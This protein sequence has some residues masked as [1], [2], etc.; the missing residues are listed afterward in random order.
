MRFLYEIVFL[1]N[2]VQALSVDCPDMIN[3][4]KGLGVD[5]TQPAI[6][7][8]INI[9]CCSVSG[10]TCFGQRVTSINW[11]SKGLNGT[12]NGTAVPVGVTYLDISLNLLSG[13][14][15]VNY[16]NAIATLYNDVNRLT[17]TIPTTLP[18][19]L[20]DFWVDG[21]FLTGDV[22]AFPPSLVKLALGYP[23]YPGND[24]TGVLRLNRPIRIWINNNWITD[25][26]IQDTSQISFPQCDFSE[27]PLLGNANIAGLA[28]TKN[29]LYSPSMLPNTRSS[30]TLK[31][32]WVSSSTITTTHGQITTSLSPNEVSTAFT[33]TSTIPKTSTM[34]PTMTSTMTFSPGVI[35]VGL[36]TSILEST[37]F[38]TTTIESNVEIATVT[39]IVQQ[40]L[41]A[42][43]AI[44]STITSFSNSYVYHFNSTTFKIV[45]STNVQTFHQFAAIVHTITIAELIR[46]AIKL[47]NDVA[48]LAIVI[49][50]MPI[51][52]GQRQIFQSKRK[53]DTSYL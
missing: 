10:I 28:C 24:F 16:P 29:G 17:G 35:T 12:I 48:L 14:I 13:S 22:P 44:A 18:T 41:L 40:T 19:S 9:N 8:A 34:V 47:L 23:G 1:L 11:Q 27:N 53:T 2:R 39:N 6:W 45:Q 33:T 51:K 4:A 31:S 20:L 49:T 43:H 42:T 50:R 37:T 25:V 15:P 52:R 38:I 5:T 21:N 7:S 36:S 3:F 30:T 26:I 32:N 46:L